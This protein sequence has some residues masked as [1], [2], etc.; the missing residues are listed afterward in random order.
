MAAMLRRYLIA[1]LAY[2]LIARPVDVIADP[3]VTNSNAIAQSSA[4]ALANEASKNKDEWTTY[5]LAQP[6]EKKIELYT[7][8]NR[9]EPGVFAL[10]KPLT[11]FHVLPN[12]PL[13]DDLISNAIE[14]VATQNEYEPASFIISSG[15]WPLTN[16]TVNVSHLVSDH[17]DNSIPPNAFDLRTVKAWYQSASRMRRNSSN[18]IKQ[19]VPELLLHDDTLVDVD[20]RRQVNFV[21]TSPP[22]TDASNLL[23]FNIPAN[24]NKQLWLSFRAPKSTTAGQYTGKILINWSSD[25]NEAESWLNIRVTILPFRLDPTRYRIGM[26]YLGRLASDNRPHF[27]ARAK[28]AMQMEHDFQSMNEHGINLI[29]LD[30]HYDDENPAQ[31]LKKLREATALA[32]NSGIPMDELVYVDWAVAASDSATRY[33]KKISSVVSTLNL[34]GVG[35]IGI[36]NADEKKYEYLIKRKHTFEIAHRYGAFNIVALTNPGIAMKLDALL[37]IAIL[38][39]STPANVLEELILNGTTPLAYGVPHAAEEKPGT[40]RFTYG[41]GMA[42]KPFSGVFSYAYQSGECWNDWHSWDKNS[43]RP[44]CMTYPTVS[45]PIP[46][47]QWEAFREAVDDLRYLETCARITKSEPK[48]LLSDIVA[49]TGRD[50]YAIRNNLLDRIS[51]ALDEE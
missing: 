38:Q 14:L 34:E 23:P 41:Y 22:I 11:D 4:I 9:T 51:A 32:K 33:E 48:Q 37:D 43:Y 42:L 28:N 16:V 19:L 8:N 50:A 7:N 10:T 21:R 31:S 5:G 2:A 1:C 18:E 44:S 27:S 24:T 25:G 26:F 17:G 3:A 45:K 46:T 35:R 30:H 15:S 6:Y 29:G 49:I 12:H 13:P 47:M 20:H 39:H 36:Y 40:V